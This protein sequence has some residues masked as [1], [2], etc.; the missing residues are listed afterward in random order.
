MFGLHLRA[1]RKGFN[2][3]SL[4]AVD[5]AVHCRHLVS[6]LGLELNV[7]YYANSLHQHCAKYAVFQSSI[8]FFWIINHVMKG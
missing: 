6:I 5:Y 1:T 7:T 4:H 2:T 8:E 3:C